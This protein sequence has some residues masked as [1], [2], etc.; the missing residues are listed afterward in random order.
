MKKTIWSIIIFMILSITGCKQENIQVRLKE[1]TF[2]HNG[3]QIP[4]ILGEPKLSLEYL[5]KNNYKSISS[6]KKEIETYADAMVYLKDRAY[7]V[8]G[9]DIVIVSWSSCLVQPQ[10]ILQIA[11][12]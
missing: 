11:F 4:V 10:H 1:E 9:N 8:K 12:G 5:S 7:S 3:I 2:T 6:M